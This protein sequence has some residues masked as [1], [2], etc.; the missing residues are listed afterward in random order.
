M[1]GGNDTMCYTMKNVGILWI[2]Y[3]LGVKCN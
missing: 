1:I 2:R 3:A